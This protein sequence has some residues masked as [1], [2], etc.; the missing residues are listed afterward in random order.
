MRKK[1]AFFAGVCSMIV[2]CSAAIILQHHEWIGWISGGISI[3]GVMMSGLLMGAW[4][5]GEETRA[6][7]HSE[8]KEHRIWRLDTAF[9]IMIF[10]LPH[11]AV[12]I[13]YVLM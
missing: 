4:T 6:T 8:T 10:A 2:I 3:I 9:L 11:M 5:S 7:Y 1:H 12:S 13:F